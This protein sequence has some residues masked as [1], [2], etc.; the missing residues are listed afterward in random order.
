MSA[1]I[2]VICPLDTLADRI[3]RNL[4]SE[5]GLRLEIGLDLIEAKTMMAHGEFGAWLE[6]NFSLSVRSAQNY[7][8]AARA[9]QRLCGLYELK[10][11][12][13]A[14]LPMETT[15]ALAN[16]PD[17]L[18]EQVVRAIKAGCKVTE[19]EVYDVLLKR[20]V[21]RPSECRFDKDELE[22]ALDTCGTSHCPADDREAARSAI[23]LIA[24]L[25]QFKTWY[26]KAGIAFDLELFGAE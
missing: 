17:N 24:D 4:K 18:Q 2:E 26:R 23:A 5:L 19:K 12:D 16:A 11:E 7:M 21:P 15:T 3:R 6:K 14:H 8:Q 20:I 10:Y 25:E 22:A 9:A 13:L 1:L